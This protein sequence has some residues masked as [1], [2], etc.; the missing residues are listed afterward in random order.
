[1][2]ILNKLKLC[3]AILGVA[4][5]V[6]S[7]FVWG[8]APATKTTVGGFN[9]GEIKLSGEILAGRFAKQPVV[10]YETQAGDTLFALQLKP[11]LK[12]VEV[13]PRDL[14]VVV[15]TSASQAGKFL[16]ASHKIVEQLVKDAAP[17]DRLSVWVINTPAATRC[18]SKGLELLDNRS[19]MS[20][21]INALQSEYASGAVDLKGA[22]DKVLKD[23]DGKTARQQ[24]ILYLGDAESA[25][26]PLNEK[27][28]FQL[29]NKIRESKVQFFAVPLGTSING[30]NMHS[31]VAGSGGS[32]VRFSDDLRDAKKLYGDLSHRLF[33][34]FQVPVLMPDRLTFGA[35]VAEFY[36]T[37]LPPLRSDIPTLV[38]GRF[39]K[40]K[41]PA[42]LEGTV[43]GRSGLLDTKA[44]FSEAVPP[45]AA[46]NFFLGTIVRQWSESTMKEAPSALRADRALALAF[47]QSRLTRDEY[48]TQA[49]WALGANRFETAKNLSE[50]ATR[51]D[52]NDPEVKALNRVVDKIDKGK[53]T[54]EQL[55][56][57]TGNHI[58]MKVEKQANGSLTYVRVN[59]DDL[60]KN[61]DPAPKDQPQ[62]PSGNPQ[63]L[64]K[65]EQAK[66]AIVEQQVSLTVQETLN[67]ARQLLRGG[68]P[69]SAKDLVVAQRE[70][71]KANPDI[72]ENLRAQLGNRMELLLTD[73]G[74]RGE[75]ILKTK[76]EE[77]EKIARARAH[78]MAVDSQQSREESTRSRINAFATLMAQ[79]RYEDANR[80]ALYMMQERVTEGLPVPLEAQAVYQMGQAAMNLRE[81]RELARIKEDRYLLTMMQVDKASIP[82]PDEPPVHFPPSK[83]WRDLLETR[84]RYSD[85]I[86]GEIVSPRVRRRMEA[87]KSALDQPMAEIEKNE[88]GLTL[89]LQTIEALATPL[90]A[91]RDPTRK[92]TIILSTEFN[93]ADPTFDAE[94]KQIKI[95]R[96][97]GVSLATVLRIICDQL[98]ATYWVRRD[99]IE[100]VPA[101]M[102]IREKVTAALPVADL[103][104]GI[105]NAINQSALSQSLAVLGQ[106]FSLGGGPAGGPVVFNGNAGGF[107]GFQFVGGG[108]GGIGGIGGGGIGGGGGGQFGGFGAGAAG[109]LFN[110]GCGGGIAGFGGGI[111]G[112]F[113]NLGGQFGF[114]SQ[115]YGPVL[116][117]LITEV[118]AKGEWAPTSQQ[119]LFCRQRAGAGAVDPDVDS[120]SL[121]TPEKLNS[122][123]YWPP[124]R[125]LIVRGTSRIHPTNSSKLR[126]SGMMPVNL[127]PPV[128]G[129]PDVIGKVAGVVKADPKPDPKAPAVDRAASKDAIVRRIME[130]E[131]NLDPE[132]IYQMLLENGMTQPGE[133]I[134]VVD[135]MVSCKQFKHAAEL[136]KASLRT[137]LIAE[138]WSQEALAI[139]LEGSQG[140]A[141]EIERARLSAIDLAPN[142]PHAYVKAARAMAD[143]GQMDRALKFCREAARL[144]P[145]LPDS[146]INALAFAGDK[147][148]SLD[149]G[150]S[151]WAAGNLLT[152]DWTSDTAEYHLLAREHLKEQMAKFVAQNKKTDVQ[153]VQAVLDNEKRRDLVVELLWSG[154]ADLDLKVREPIGTRC[155]STEPRTPGGGVLLCDDFT[156]KEDNRSETY[157]ASE[158]Y[159]GAY[160][161]AVERVWGRPLGEKATVKVVRHQGTPEQTIELHTLTF[162]KDNPAP[163]IAVSLE[164]GRRKS[165]ASVPPAGVVPDAGRKPEREQE[166]M[167]K[168][169]AMTSGNSTASGMKGGIGSVN[170]PSGAAM[171]NTDSPLVGLTCQAS[172]GSIAPGG[173]EMRQETIMSRDG[174]SVQV[175]MAP[176]FN[177]G[178][179]GPPAKVKLEFIPGAE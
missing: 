27:D 174:K 65:T 89:L 95:P 24:I 47:E 118:V 103:I 84:K 158:A 130:K 97:V 108:I 163:K 40:G 10:A 11:A 42:K 62:V 54:L 8:D 87:L 20:A 171:E 7:A 168:L 157:T 51:M 96:L 56:A 57:A 153:K 142:S 73:I 104:I 159:N 162:S 39:A 38:V 109:G 46:E 41:A 112:Q 126:P 175:R 172:V 179:A 164:G 58:G 66:K 31:L 124:A 94:R 36:P 43:E 81:M 44:A 144:E 121:L 165:L 139:A 98:D 50:A 125:A 82:Y 72:S 2:K 167:N 155:S 135:F 92:V 59:L 145:N 16:D 86:D 150:A 85:T 74:Q 151:A 19:N 37:R 63:D 1:M 177:P 141:E 49:Q 61:D 22:I 52:P 111:M 93:R 35:E 160:E 32:V 75:A 64:L 154:P 166:V 34:A 105:P 70:S 25:I 90:G 55:K 146:Y 113:G 170:H 12:P 13:R 117:K 83:V 79:A 128:A 156:Q 101:D 4:A 106:T 14:V 71:I 132:K 120:A 78:Y 26:D 129:E 127:A 99:Y 100:I 30:L 17:N 116:I 119:E 131:K 147:K 138:P 5:L 23:F 60:A 169:W 53:M 115:D 76:A 123:G 91:D 114:Q 21:M 134:A 102:A 3:T 69:K 6:A 110:G 45:A 15:D 28:R 148:A 140:S 152:R 176:V 136:L 122:M 80:E 88:V 149:A 161:I 143:M 18:L 33:E 133:I 68:D 48:L 107:G 173:L 178:S 9:R 137:G 77:N 67:R 29:A